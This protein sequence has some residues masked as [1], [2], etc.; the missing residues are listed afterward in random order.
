[1]AKLHAISS[2]FFIILGI[3]SPL[4]AADDGNGTISGAGVYVKV[5]GQSGKIMMSRSENIQSDENRVTVEM[6]EIKETDM[7]GNPVGAGGAPA[8]KHSFN[9]FANQEFEYS[10]VGNGEFENISAKTFNFSATIDNGAKLLVDVFIFTENGTYSLNGENTTVSEGTVKFNI[11]IENWTF[12]G[13]GVTCSKGSTTE[14]GKYIDFTIAIKG[15]G[16]SPQKKTSGGKKTTADEYDLGS[17]SSVIISD[18]VQ[19]DDNGD[20]VPTPSGYPKLVQKGSKTLFVFRFDKFS[21]SVLYD[22]QVDLGKSPDTTDTPTTDRE[23][24]AEGVWVKVLGKSG[25]IQVGNRQNPSQD[26]N[27]ITIEFSELKEK[28]TDGSDIQ[29]NKHRFNNFAVTDFQFTSPIDAEFMNLTVK[30]FTFNATLNSEGAMLET[31]VL[32]FREDGDL[33]LGNETTMVKKGNMKFSTTIKDWKFCGQGATTCS[34]SETGE[35]LDFGMIIKGK[36]TPKKKQDSDKGNAEEYDLGEDS[37]V[38]MSRKVKYNTDDWTTMASGYPMVMT[39]GSKQIFYIRLNKFT[40]TAYYDP[41]VIYSLGDTGGSSR[42]CVS[43]FT[44]F[45]FAFLSVFL[46]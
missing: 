24:N 26:P 23:T 6:D 46:F 42:N 10:E 8:T 7:S 14:I 1:M 13:A 12:C 22:P 28:K 34:Q 4:A 21:K 39:Q 30:K 36:G 35:F 29:D 16:A 20:W 3:L 44:C 40:G 38:V 9:T 37:S 31:E 43:L 45:L 33:T 27:R 2:V 18:K 11:H 41:T 17:G 15:K 5:L 25:K 32:I 19:Y